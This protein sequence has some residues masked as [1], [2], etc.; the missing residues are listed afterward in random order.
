M[1]G[2]ICIR[3]AVNIEALGAE[4]CEVHRNNSGQAVVFELELPFEQKKQKRRWMH[5]RRKTETITY[6]PAL[7]ASLYMEIR[8]RRL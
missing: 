3:Q 5:H 2:I 8:L 7:P 6:A 1:P 4:V